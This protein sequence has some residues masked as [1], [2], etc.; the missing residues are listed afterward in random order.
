MNKR[1][2][3]AGII[4]I[5]VAAVVV[6]LLVHNPKS[7]TPASN[8]QTY[9][10]QSNGNNHASSQIITTRTDSSGAQY[11]A[12]GNGNPLYNYGGD[13]SGVSNCVGA[14]LVDWPIY[15]PASTSASLPANVSVITRSDGKAQYAYKGL[16]LY[17]FS[18]DTSGNPTGDNVSDFHL[19]KP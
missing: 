16:P 13:S 12:D 5:V 10:S 14:C 19:A 3:G 17:F 18:S 6:F 1:N 9:S 11:V 7:T 4:V 8:A 15:T 2:L